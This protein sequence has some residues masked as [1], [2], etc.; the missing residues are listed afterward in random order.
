MSNINNVINN[1]ASVLA[2]L[3]RIAEALR[4]GRSRG[5]RRN[6]I[7]I[8]MEKEVSA[9][10]KEGERL[11]STMEWPDAEDRGEFAALIERFKGLQVV[12]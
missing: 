1:A 7:M 12:S 8:S 10:I 11:L 3:D 2:R 4:D 6:E 9:T 5:L